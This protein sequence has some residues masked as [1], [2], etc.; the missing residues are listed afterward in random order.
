[1]VLPE[2]ASAGG[3]ESPSLTPIAQIPS[4]KFPGMA[5]GSPLSPGVNPD[6]L[7]PVLPPQALPSVSHPPICLSRL[8]GQPEPSF[9]GKWSL[10]RPRTVVSVVEKS[11]AYQGLRR[12]YPAGELMKK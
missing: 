11:V 6:L 10:L 7:I 5:R 12:F 2:G 3:P 9:L 8:L 1:M 4:T